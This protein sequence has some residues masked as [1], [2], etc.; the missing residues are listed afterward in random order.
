M[1]GQFR[2]SGNFTTWAA[3]AEN[4]LNAVTVSQR[5]VVKNSRRMVTV[6]W[7]FVDRLG[8]QIG[9]FLAKGLFIA[10]LVLVLLLAVLVLLLLLA[11]QPLH[12][13]W[14]HQAN[15]RC[16]R[17][18]VVL[19]ARGRPASARNFLVRNLRYF[20]PLR[21]I[22]TLTPSAYATSLDGGGTKK[23]RA[24]TYR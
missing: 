12:L 13:V 3:F 20:R 5:W 1:K 9:D 10:V 24:A 16:A 8:S 18:P 2:S 22:I 21:C 11:L 17:R 4:G 23:W 6:T 19:P 7:K 14:R 15:A